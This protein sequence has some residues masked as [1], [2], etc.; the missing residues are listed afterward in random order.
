MSEAA[1]LPGVRVDLDSLTEALYTLAAAH[2]VLREALAPDQAALRVVALRHEV[3]D[4]LATWTPPRD[5]YRARDLPSP[6]V[7]AA[8]VPPVAN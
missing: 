7:L 5:S 6:T 1:P 3:R 4:A 2:F 8:E